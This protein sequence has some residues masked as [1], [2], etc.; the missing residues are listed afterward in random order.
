MRLLV[1]DFSGHPF[2][3][4]LSRALARRGHSV[5]HAYCASLETPQAGLV[6]NEDDPEDFVIRPLKL[7]TTFKRYGLFRRILQE[8]AYGQLVQKGIEQFRPDLVMCSNTPLGAVKLIQ[9]MCRNKK[10]GFVFWVQDLLGV[11]ITSGLKKKLPVIGGVI[12]WHFQGLEAS[13]LRKSDQIVVITPDFVDILSSMGVRQDRIR[14]IPNWAPL[15]EVPVLA[16]GNPWAGEQELE[17]K[18]CYLYSG[19]LGMKHNPEL[20]LHLA[21]R[22]HD[23]SRI[24]VV[25]VSEGPGAEYLRER[26]AESGL[27]NLILLPFQPYDRLPEVLATGDVFIGILEAESGVFSVPSKVLTYLCA[28]RPLLLSVPPENLAARIVD[29]N[30][31]GIIVS[32]ADTESFVEKAVE[33]ANDDDLRRQLAENCRRYAEKNFDI[34]T[35]AERFEGVFDK[36]VNSDKCAK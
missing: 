21:E 22:F 31:A 2:Q 24:R 30:K 18:F 33:L 14:V 12:G 3:I 7:A 25:V 34:N 6:K 26:K 23:D 5:M 4:Q 35:I 19:T 32:P 13:L 10:T 1:N 8:K 11:G 15:E 20:L 36:I 17:D 29:D 27:G 28:K 16:R 9:R